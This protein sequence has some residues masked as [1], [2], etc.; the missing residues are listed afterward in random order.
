VTIP[1]PRRTAHIDLAEAQAA[2]ESAPGEARSVALFRNGTL[3]VKLYA[4]CG[5][6]PQTP[7]TRDEVYI[8]AE[9][10][11]VFFDGEA[12]WPF[13]PGTFLFAGARRHRISTASVPDYA[14]RNSSAALTSSGAR[15]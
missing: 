11:G 13:A 6:D 5:H 8:V 10:H 2:L 14:R 9:G 15:F 12:R 7:H 1:K 3:Q 4:L